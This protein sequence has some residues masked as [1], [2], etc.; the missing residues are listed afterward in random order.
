MPVRVLAAQ[1]ELAQSGSGAETHSRALLRSIDRRDWH[2]LAS[3]MYESQE[4]GPPLL[5]LAAPAAVSLAFYA[6][7]SLDGLKKYGGK[8]FGFRER[9]EAGDE[10]ML[11]QIIGGCLQVGVTRSGPLTAEQKWLRTVTLRKALFQLGASRHY[12]EDGAPCD[13]AS[14]WATAGSRQ[15]FSRQR[16][17][18]RPLPSATGAPRTPSLLE[19]DHRATCSW[20]ME[21]T[22]VLEARDA[23]ALCARLC[24][25]IALNVF[26][27]KLKQ[28]H[29]RRCMPADEWQRDWAERV[30]RYS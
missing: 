11:T 1:D 7:E 6:L 24:E 4:D 8:G 19:I 13:E 14:L 9:W 30:A 17:S 16:H 18:F 25:F 22:D 5:T 29:Y 26:E 15:S 12:A 2:A 28:K 21:Q 3:L 27:S 20:A 23:T 10:P